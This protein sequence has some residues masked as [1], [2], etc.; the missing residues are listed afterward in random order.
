MKK[1]SILIIVIVIIGSLFITYLTFDSL[2]SVKPYEDWP[3]N[4]EDDLKI[5]PQV[6]SF[7]E[8]YENEYEISIY[9]DGV[10]TYQIGI[11]AIKDAQRSNLKINY[12]NGNPTSVSYSCFIDDK[13]IPSV[14]F[15][16]KY[17]ES[18]EIINCFT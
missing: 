10:L 14:V 5:I 15:D 18:E 2:A 12:F 8:I 17:V 11:Q 3:G 13:E 9:Q 6:K 4:H 16:A 7:Y 1:K